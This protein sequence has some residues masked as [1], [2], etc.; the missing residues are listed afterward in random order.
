MLKKIRVPLIDVRDTQKVS[1]KFVRL[2]FLYLF[3]QKA[4]LLQSKKGG[5]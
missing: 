5:D 3:V 1:Y 2:S 4:F